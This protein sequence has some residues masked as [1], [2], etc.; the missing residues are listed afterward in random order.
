VQTDGR[1]KRL[2]YNTF[3][4][5]FYQ[6]TTIVCG[7]IMPRLVLTAFGSG[8][9]GLVQSVTQ[10]LGIISF[11]ELGVGA[12]VQ[13]SLYKP[14]AEHDENHI[15]RIIKSAKK[16]FR[17]IAGVLVVYVIF[18]VIFYPY[19]VKKDFG[20]IYTATLI[21]A[22]SISFFAQYYFG[23]VN[24]L[25][26]VADQ[27]GYVQYNV[28]TVSVI[29][30]TSLCF[31]LIKFG[32]GIHAIKLMTSLIYLLQPIIIH[33]YVKKHYNI[34]DKITFT[35]EPIKQKWNGI[36]QHVAAVVLDGT[37]VIVLTV[38]STLSNVS[39]YSVYFLVIKGIKT[40]L[41]SMTNGIQALI[42]EL[43]A[44]KELRQLNDLFGWIEWTIHTGTTYVFACTAALVV[45]FVEVYISGIIDA[46]YIQP[47]F[48]L[49]FTLAHAMHCL[50]L[51][52]NIMVLSAGHYKQTQRNYI[53]AAIINIVVSVLTVKV[54]GLIG[55]AIGTL[56]AMTYQTTW[57]AIYNSKQFIFWSLK[58]VA[59]Q[60]MV[61]FL[62]MLLIIVIG[63]Q[64][65]LKELS[66]IGWFNMAIKVAVLAM[67]V[68]AGLNF[69]FY[70][71]K[72]NLLAN[73]I[74]SK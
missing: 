20:Y 24:R 33:L 64:I 69:I 41:L 26:L 28:Q 55:V 42:G 54:W 71:E 4:S 6:I 29:L 58:K 48:A 53:F 1:K 52:Y 60:F 61:D 45:P 34:N 16:F 49:L 56:A 51:P 65:F 12:V 63:N 14:L 21:V 72:L 59:K 66:Y 3:S 30:N 50:R 5:L 70:R 67:F 17:T 32:F 39:V 23:I 73:K 2:A 27:R 22:I 36:A 43:W 8:V 9:N 11:L 15:S 25:L 19:F 40:L 46:N 31:L 13:S 38:F 47:M 10:F 7:F 74:R 44:K 18:L 35:K 62:G 57:L 37:D 68:V